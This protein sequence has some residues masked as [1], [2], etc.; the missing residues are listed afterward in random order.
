MVKRFNIVNNFIFVTSFVKNLMIPRD[1][2]MRYSVKI[3]LTPQ[4][5]S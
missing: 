5:H 1:S 4:C 3:Y 2:E